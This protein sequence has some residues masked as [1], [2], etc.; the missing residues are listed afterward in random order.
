MFGR[1]DN[2]ACLM[3]K[4][5]N[6]YIDITI[7]YLYSTKNPSKDFIKYK[8]LWT[9]DSIKFYYNGKLI[10]KIDDKKILD[11]CNNTTMNVILN[12]SLTKLDNNTNSDFIIKY[13]KY[14]PL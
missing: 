13:F 2:R 3:R 6:T 10:R 9:N 11:Q 14:S 8:L 5:I 12:N 1:E 7:S 4:L